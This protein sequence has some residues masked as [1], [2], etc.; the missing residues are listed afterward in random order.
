MILLLLS[1]CPGLSVAA[2]SCLVSFIDKNGSGHDRTLS[3]S[4]EL[5]ISSWLARVPLLAPVCKSLFVLVCGHRYGLLC[6]VICWLVRISFWYCMENWS[7]PMCICVHFSVVH[8]SF[9]SSMLLLYLSAL[10]WSE[11]M[12]CKTIY[13]QPVFTFC[14][15]VCLIFG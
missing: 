12:L 11:A 6:H 3:Q 1:M 5:Y 14:T 10:Q 13:W 8:K 7:A 9:S 2:L 15:I 4:R